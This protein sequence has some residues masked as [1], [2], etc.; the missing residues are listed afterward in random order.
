MNSMQTQQIP[1]KFTVPTRD[2][3]SD[4]N[5][6]VFDQ[7]SKAFG[8]VPNLYAV[9]AWNE[10][11]LVDFLQLQNRVSTLDSQE[12]EVINLVVTEIND[13][14]YTRR[15]H[16]ML[17]KSHGFTDDQVLSIR[18]VDITFNDRYRALSRFV[19]ETATSGGNPTQESVDA[20]FEAGYDLANFIDIIIVVGD[21]ITANYL[22][23]ITRIPVDFPEVPT[24][25]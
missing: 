17:A 5:K 24:I 8:N 22:Y 6:T 20:L 16:S 23:N 2:Q 7:I 10:T 15:A 9:L 11:A 13:C 12:R 21:Q 1:V 14:D 4:A 18:K 25:H 19:H 3:V